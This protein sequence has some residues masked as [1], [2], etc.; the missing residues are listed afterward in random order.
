MRG[1]LSLAL[2]PVFAVFLASAPVAAQDY[3]GSGSNPGLAGIFDEVRFGAVYPV[4]PEDNSGV[5]VSGQLYF[6]SFVPPFQNYFANTVLRPRVHLG[7]NLATREDGV[8]QVY[9]G[10]TWHFP[11]FNLFF[12]EGSFGGTYHD[13][14]LETPGDGLDLGC[15]WLFRESVAAGFDVGQRLARCRFG[16]PLVARAHL[17]RPERRK[18]RQQRHYPRRRLCRLPLLRSI[19]GVHS[20]RE[21]AYVT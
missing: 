2:L 6:K 10:L 17:R 3:S 21:V 7:G 14:P 4:Q 9:G 1:I 16:R 8:S 11:I 20:A 13:G 12:V 18:G 19:D 15:H 5:I